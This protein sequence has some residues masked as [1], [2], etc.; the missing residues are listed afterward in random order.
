MRFINSQYFLNRQQQ[1]GRVEIRYIEGVIELRANI[2]YAAGQKVQSSEE[3]HE[4]F[5]GAG[6]KLIFPI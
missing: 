3:H 5:S 6:V 4:F 1:I 2:S